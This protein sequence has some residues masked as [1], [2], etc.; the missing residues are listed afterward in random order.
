MFHDIAIKPVSSNPHPN[1]LDVHR[2]QVWHRRFW[3][4]LRLISWHLS[5]QLMYH[6]RCHHDISRHVIL[7]SP[8]ACF[9]IQKFSNI[10]PIIG[11]CPKAQ[12]RHPENMSTDVVRVN[13]SK[14][15]SLKI[16]PKLFQSQPP[17]FQG[18]FPC[19]ALRPWAPQLSL[20]VG[21]GVGRRDT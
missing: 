20:F 4:I 8:E 6:S 3:P 18:S 2:S 17:M 1:Q 21:R 19:T 5:W 9:F 12:T 10:L 11:V 15:K 14:F 7:C 13:Y 16:I